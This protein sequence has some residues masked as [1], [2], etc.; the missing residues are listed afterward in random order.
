MKEDGASLQKLLDENYDLLGAHEETAQHWDRY[1]IG[2]DHKI[3]RG[4]VDAVHCR[5]F[6]ANVIVERAVNIQDLVGE[7]SRFNYEEE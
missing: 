4:L 2:I 6:L 3:E 1:L 5:Y 7:N